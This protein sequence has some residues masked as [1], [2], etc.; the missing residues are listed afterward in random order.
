MDYQLDRQTR[1]SVERRVAKVEQRG[2]MRLI[3]Y[4]PEI[5]D[6][7]G[8]PVFVPD[9][10]P[11]VQQKARQAALAAGKETYEIPSVKAT[12]AGW[13]LHFLRG[14]PFD[15]NERGQPKAPLSLEDVGHGFACVQAFRKAEA[16]KAEHVRLTPEDAKWLE[17]KVETE[18]VVAYRI[19]AKVLLSRLADFTNQE[20]PKS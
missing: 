3:K 2:R 10:N 6:P 14:L 8:D 11:E 13:V 9:P 4:Q 15:K 12:F 5:Q 7:Y 18:G 20:D 17:G 19:G 1:R 16:D